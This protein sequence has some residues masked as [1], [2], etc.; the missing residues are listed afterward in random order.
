M[1]PAAVLPAA[2]RPRQRAP[3]EADED[4]LRQQWIDQFDYLYAESER[5]GPRIMALPLHAWAIGQPYRIG[6]LA[7][8]LDHI[9]S[10]PGVWAATGGQIMDA[11]KAS[12]AKA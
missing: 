7:D 10:K 12:H 2:A 1:P 9:L 3:S 8:V 6:V 11:W 4:D 5:H